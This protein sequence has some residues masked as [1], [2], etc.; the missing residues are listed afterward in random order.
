MYASIWK[1]EAKGLEVQ[2]HPRLCMSLRPAWTY[3]GILQNK[4]EQQNPKPQTCS[5]EIGKL[6]LHISLERQVQNQS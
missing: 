1:A 4:A 3:W 5:P 6:V 2:D